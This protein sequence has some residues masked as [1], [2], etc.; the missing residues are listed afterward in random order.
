MCLCL[1]STNKSDYSHSH[2]P[3][4]PFTPNQPSTSLP[5]TRNQDLKSISASHT[6]Y[7]FEILHQ[8]SPSALPIYAQSDLRQRRIGSVPA[9]QESEAGASTQSVREFT[10]ESGRESSRLARRHQHFMSY[11]EEQEQRSTNL[12]FADD[13]SGSL[14]PMSDQDLIVPVVS[15]LLDS[16][17]SSYTSHLSRLSYSSHSELPFK[18]DSAAA[19]SPSR[20]GF[21]VQTNLIH[22]QTVLF[23]NEVGRFFV[24]SL[25][26]TPY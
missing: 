14:S 6:S 20:E 1:I 7:P 21:D 3:N 18:L 10:R 5:V 11:D 17:Q 9:I 25:L 16:R 26:K 8:A 22:N 15:G 24:Y 19:E 2:H 13:E 12:P 4:G 23:Q